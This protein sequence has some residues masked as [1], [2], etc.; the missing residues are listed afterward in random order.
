MEI[1]NADIKIRGKEKDNDRPTN[2]RSYT[3]MQYFIPNNWPQPMIN[4]NELDDNDILNKFSESEND[5]GFGF[6]YRFTY[7]CHN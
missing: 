1:I 7:D 4:G 2:N 6:D 5:D 3:N